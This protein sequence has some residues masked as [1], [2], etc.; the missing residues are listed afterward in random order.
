MGQQ[1]LAGRNLHAFDSHR[2]I[3]DSR[4]LLSV[5]LRRLDVEPEQRSLLGDG[6]AGA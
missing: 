2:H 1:R 4:S 6:W 5:D 3:D